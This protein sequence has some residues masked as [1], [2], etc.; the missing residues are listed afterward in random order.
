M[1]RQFLATADFNNKYL[2]LNVKIINTAL[3]QISAFAIPNSLQR[4]AVGYLESYHMFIES[5]CLEN[6]LSTII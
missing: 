2:S 6:N 1:L 4:L 3:L 5:F